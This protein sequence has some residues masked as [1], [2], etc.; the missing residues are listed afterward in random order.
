M[1]PL[2]GKLPALRFLGL[3]YEK[4]VGQYDEFLRSAPWLEEL[5]VC[6]RDGVLAKPL[7]LLCIPGSTL[8][9]LE[10]LQGKYPSLPSFYRPWTAVE[11]HELKKICPMLSVLNIDIPRQTT[12]VRSYPLDST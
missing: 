5:A 11:L 12:W 7:P 4:Y 1:Q 9:S 2:C 3:N 8:T 6:H 10:Y